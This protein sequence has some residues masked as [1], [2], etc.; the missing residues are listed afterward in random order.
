MLFD[1]YKQRLDGLILNVIPDKQDKMPVQ[2]YKLDDDF[3]HINGDS[4]KTA[5]EQ[6]EKKVEDNCKSF[7]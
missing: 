2:T 5:N 4:L 6:I 3:D 7:V 1:Y